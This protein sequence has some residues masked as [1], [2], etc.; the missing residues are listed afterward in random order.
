VRRQARDDS[1]RLRVALIA[2]GI[3]S[4]LDE[5]IELLLGDV[6]EG[7]MAQVVGQ[8]S[9]FNDV[10][11]EVLA[12]DLVPLLPQELLGDPPR[13]LRNLEGVGQ[14]IVEDMPF[15]RADDL[16]YFSKPPKGRG[17]EN[18]VSILLGCLS[19]IGV[20]DLTGVLARDSR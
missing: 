5:L 8:R 19:A 13:Q 15:E 7:R 18:P 11:I 3:T 12:F 16:G 2:I 10:R 4:I 9:R 1:E 20:S 6:P 14:A 17:V